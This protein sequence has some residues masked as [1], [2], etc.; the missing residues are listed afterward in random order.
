MASTGRREKPDVCQV[1]NYRFLSAKT[2]NC[3]HLILA[4]ALGLQALSPNK[5]RA[6]NAHGACAPPSKT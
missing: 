1:N 5:E 2:E 4:Q 6:M 3:F